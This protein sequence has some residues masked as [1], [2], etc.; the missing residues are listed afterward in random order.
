[1]E[2]DSQDSLTM[3]THT[4][5]TVPESDIGIIDQQ[6]Q[7]EIQRACA[8]SDILKLQALAESPGGLLTD[9]LRQRACALH[10]APCQV[11]HADKSFVS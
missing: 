3:S 11:L 9:S 8:R 10:P 4:E 1:M 7:D 6:K 2:P 5:K